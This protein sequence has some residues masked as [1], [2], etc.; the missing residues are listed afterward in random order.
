[1]TD[2]HQKLPIK[3]R[4]V[5]R[6]E[7]VDKRRSSCLKAAVDK[8]CHAFKNGCRPVTNAH[9]DRV[10]KISFLTAVATFQD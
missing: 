9:S 7:W 6:P 4:A 8:A 5:Q 2:P 10:I 1:M 3:W